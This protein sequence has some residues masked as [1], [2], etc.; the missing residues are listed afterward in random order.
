MHRLKHNIMLSSKILEKLFEKIDE[1]EK[2]EKEKINAQYNEI[3]NSDNSNDI[4][5]DVDDD[6]DDEIILASVDEYQFDLDEIKNPTDN[7][8]LK[9]HK[10]FT[11]CHGLAV[12]RSCMQ[13]LTINKTTAMKTYN[14]KNN[15]L[16]N[17]DCYQYKNGFHG[18]T[19]FYLTKEIRLMAIVIRFGLVNP[20]LNQYSNCVQTLLEEAIERDKKSQERGLKMIEARERNKELKLKKEQLE[21]DERKS[22][23][24]KALAIKNLIID[25]DC[26]ACHDYLI[27]NNSNLKCTVNQTKDYSK[28]KSKLKAELAK[29]NLVIRDDSYYCR[30]YL[31]GKKFTLQETVEMM[32]IMDFFANK[33]DYFSLTKACV[34]KQ[35]DNAKEFRYWNG[36]KITLCEEE[37][38]EIKVLALKKYL[39]NHTTK[40]VPQSVLERY[41]TCNNNKKKTILKID[42]D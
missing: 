31:A 19:N 2:L 15:D 21:Y 1:L 35:Y 39:L 26:K 12:C 37:K 33:T 41:N 7:H 32:E 38:D 40:N 20:S 3:D 4:D 28:R 5:D 13:D 9:C 11:N 24:K 27:G 10:K 25:T 16:E 14:L 23:L 18:Y 8:C 17:I 6:T 22:K 30:K 34:Q 29:K 36:E 42:S